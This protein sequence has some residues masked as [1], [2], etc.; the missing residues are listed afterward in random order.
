MYRKLEICFEKLYLGS[1]FASYFSDS[2]LC[3]FATKFSMIKVVI[4]SF[5]LIDHWSNL[6]LCT[7]SYEFLKMTNDSG[8]QTGQHHLSDEIWSDMHVSN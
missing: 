7:L 1:H 3:P 2:E 4:M 8:K 6:D 5:N